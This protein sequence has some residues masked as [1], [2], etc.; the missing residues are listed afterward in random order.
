MLERRHQEILRNRELEIIGDIVRQV[1]H[2]IR[3]PLS[4]LNM[5][6]ARLD[7]LPADQRQ[8]IQAAAKR[9]NGIANDLLQRHQSKSQSDCTFPGVHAVSVMKS[10]T[11]IAELLRSIFAEKQASYSGEGCVELRLDLAGPT[12]AICAIDEKEMLRVLSNLINNAVEALGGKGT[13]TLA[14][15]SSLKKD[16]AVIV[17]DNGKGI[18]EHLLARLGKEKISFGKDGTESGSGIGV[19]HAKSAVESMGGKFAIQS[20]VGMGTII[21]MTFPRSIENPSE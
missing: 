21:T 19:F 15:R 7:D 17:S 4:A 2:D 18:P 14:L 1:S 20:K 16:V 8:I 12:D 11:N 6:V 3:S 10:A 13:V 5:V 9:I